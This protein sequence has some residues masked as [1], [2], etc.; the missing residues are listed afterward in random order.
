MPVFRPR[1]PDA[2]LRAQ[3]AAAE[4]AHEPAAAF[5]AEACGWVPGTG[6]CRYRNCAAACLFEPQRAAEA[7]RITRW[8]RLRR[9]LSHRRD[10][11]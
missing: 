1:T 11:P 9:M 4:L 5:W 6:H 8:R 2:P 7:H 10:T 3:P